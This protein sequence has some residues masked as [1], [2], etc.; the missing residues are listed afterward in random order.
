MVFVN[1]KDEGA[2]GNGIADDTEAIIKAINK[3]KRALGQD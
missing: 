3:L 2:I 1:V